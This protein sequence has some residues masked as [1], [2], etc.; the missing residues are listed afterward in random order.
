MQGV[1]PTAHSVTP[2]EPLADRV[3]YRNDDGKATHETDII[4]EA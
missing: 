2:D 1:T 3:L 4:V